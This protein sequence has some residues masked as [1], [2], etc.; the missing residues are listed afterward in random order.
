MLNGGFDLWSSEKKEINNETP[1]VKAS[2]IKITEIKPDMNISTDDL[3]KEY[4]DLKVI[5][6]RAKDEYEGAVNYGEARGGHLPDAINV[7]FT[8]LYNED[9][10]LKNKEEKV[11]IMEKA[12]VKKDDNIV[13]YCTAGIRSAHMAFLSLKNAGFENVRNYDSSFYEWAAGWKL[14]FNFDECTIKI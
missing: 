3:K 1:E 5:D 2:E 8:E 14:Y 11:K 6:T 12:G 7:P 9:G 13:T 4:K 10:T